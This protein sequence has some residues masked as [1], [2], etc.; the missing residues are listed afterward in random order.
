MGRPSTLTI[1]GITWHWPPPCAIETRA[2]FRRDRPLVVESTGDWSIYRHVDLYFRPALSDG[3]GDGGWCRTDVS[4]VLY[5]H[6]DGVHLGRVPVSPHGTF[7]WTGQ[8]PAYVRSHRF[9]RV[10]AVADEGS[11]AVW[12]PP[13]GWSRGPRSGIPERPDSAPGAPQGTLVPRRAVQPGRHRGRVL[14]ERF[15]THGDL[16]VGIPFIEQYSNCSVVE[17]HLEGPIGRYGRLVVRLT[18]TGHHCQFDRGLGDQ[19]AA[20]HIFV[21]TPPIPDERVTTLA[22]AVALQSQPLRRGGPERA[23][24]APTTLILE[25]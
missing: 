10:L 3:L 2:A 21:V 1:D 22:F 19:S 6:P 25:P 12:S 7:T 8:Y 18:I 23:T 14:I 4:T 11:Y 17:V 13:F 24:V 15:K 16:R 5:D 20:D 9:Y